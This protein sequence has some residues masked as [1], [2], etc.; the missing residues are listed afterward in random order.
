VLT[1]A[2]SNLLAEIKVRF[3]GGD[4]ALLIVHVG[5]L[6]RINLQHGYANG[7]LMLSNTIERVRGVARE[8]DFMCALGGN[9]AALLLTGVSSEGQAKLAAQKVL[10]E[11][12]HPF[13]L[14]DVS[15]A[16]VAHIGVAL[17][18][19]VDDTPSHL[20]TNAE[21][22]LSAARR[23]NA[24][25]EVASPDVS[26]ANSQHVLSLDVGRALDKNEFL[27]FFQPT[28]DLTNGKMVGA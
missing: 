13:K 17:T 6:A 20:I 28:V 23:K 27:V 3:S 26:G 1:K 14:G 10:R 19:D 16:L 21:T 2:Y 8:Q 4:I 24:G 22:A 15:V 12:R 9:R 5:N 25:Y 11:I 18:G 7:D